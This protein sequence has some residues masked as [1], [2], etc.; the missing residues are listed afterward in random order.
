M[1]KLRLVVPTLCLIAVLAVAPATAYGNADGPQGGS[2]STKS[3]PPP[4]PPPSVQWL[5]D[6]IIS[7]LG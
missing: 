2:N 3:A 1:K 7:L 6:L 4:P 5:I